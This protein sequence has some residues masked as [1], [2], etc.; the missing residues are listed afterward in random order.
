M[1]SGETMASVRYRDSLPENISL[2]SLSKALLI[3]DAQIY[4]IYVTYIV[5]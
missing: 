4:D 5:N 1:V 2:S 3:F